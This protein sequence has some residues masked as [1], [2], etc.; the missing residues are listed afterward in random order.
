M[1]I[2]ATL[3]YLHI[4]PRKVRLVAGLIRG[5]DARRA[6]L[7]LTAL[8][9][10]AS[11]PMLKLLRS[12]QA[13]ARHNFQIPSGSFYVKEIRVNAGP[14]AKRFRARAFGRAA[15][16]R[17]RTS[18][19][20]LVLEARSLPDAPSARLAKRSAPVVR[21]QIGAEAIHEGPMKPGRREGKSALPAK[22]KIPSV[23]RRIFQRKA[24]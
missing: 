11:A 8:P 19:V 24:I 10:R 9:K 7:V 13:N 2:K 17:K 18:H 20:S 4:A 16:I 15:P 6:E 23:M 21:D 5:M 22:P 1:E 12:A 14:V 3:Q